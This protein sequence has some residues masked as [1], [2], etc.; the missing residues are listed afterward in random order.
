MIVLLAS[1]QF[2]DD[3]ERLAQEAD[4]T[5]SRNARLALVAK[6]YASYGDYP[7]STVVRFDFDKDGL[8]DFFSPASTQQERDALAVSLD[9]DIDGDGIANASDATPYCSVCEL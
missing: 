5:T 4:Y 3:A 7:D 6:G 2:F 1:A 9:D 8:P